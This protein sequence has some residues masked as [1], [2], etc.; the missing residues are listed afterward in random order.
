M[1]HR[2]CSSAILLEGL[3]LFFCEQE[4]CSVFMSSI[5]AQDFII[6]QGAASSLTSPLPLS[7]SI[8]GRKMFYRIL[9][10]PQR[11]EDNYDCLCKIKSFSCV[12][13]YLAR[14]RLLC[15]GFGVFSRMF[16][17]PPGNLAAHGSHSLGAL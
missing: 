12:S 16:C 15:L 2:C 7:D 17:L 5:P 10:F 11:E 6:P 13:L 14:W 4:V 1:Q 8:L 9:V 3:W